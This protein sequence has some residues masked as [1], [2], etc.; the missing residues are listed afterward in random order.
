MITADQLTV[1]GALGRTHGNHGEL[2]LLTHNDYDDF[3]PTF[4]IVLQD[5]IFVPFRLLAQQRRNSSEYIVRLLGIDSEPSAAALC[6]KKAYC[7]KCE[8]PASDGDADADI[9]GY[10]LYDGERHVGT[11][12]YLDDSTANALFVLQDGTLVPA[13][14]DLIT[15]VD[16][17][18]RH[19]ICQLP[20]G[21]MG[22]D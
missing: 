19:I 12:N 18:K 16:H 22:S 10:E 5:N 11:I 14:E 15:E 20:E 7:R 13:H 9:S 6:G 17:N 3:H 4:I 1:I 21:L 8:M 2:L